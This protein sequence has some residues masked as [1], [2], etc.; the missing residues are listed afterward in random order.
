VT[1]RPITTE[2][3]QRFFTRFNAGQN[4]AIVEKFARD[5]FGPTATNVVITLGSEYNDEG[6]DTV[7][8]EVQVFDADE[9]EL[10]PDFTLP[11]WVE[12]LAQ[13]RADYLSWASGDYVEEN[14]GISDPDELGYEVRAILVGGQHDLPL[15]SGEWVLGS[16]TNGV[17]VLYVEEA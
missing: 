9:N 5:L 12:A 13:G 4:E 17:P 15:Q 2:E 7:I 8:D 6:Y 11:Y 14:W 10:K 3:L 1:Y 16:A